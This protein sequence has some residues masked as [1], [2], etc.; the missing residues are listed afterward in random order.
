MKIILTYLIVILSFNS[1][2]QTTDYLKRLF[3]GTI[4]K[5]EFLISQKYSDMDSVQGF[6]YNPYIYNKR[7]QLVDWVWV[8]DFKQYHDTTK[9]YVIYDLVTSCN[10]IYSEYIEIYD[11]VTMSMVRTFA[12]PYL[13]N[14]S[15]MG[16]IYDTDLGN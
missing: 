2:G 5:D 1:V 13:P 7:V 15:I 14:T 11:R 3:D 16:A 12:S 4:T 9:Y 10:T 6:L 8:T